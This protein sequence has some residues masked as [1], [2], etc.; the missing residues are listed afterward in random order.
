MKIVSLSPSITD[1]LV[2]IGA[3]EDIVGITPFCRPWL[4]GGSAEIAGDYFRIKEDVV[5]RLR[6][7]VIFLQSHVHDKLY[8]KL[9][10]EYNTHLISLP[11]SI[12]NAIENMIKIG[13]IV[14]RTYE[15]RALA[16]EVLS[17]IYGSVESPYKELSERPKVYVEYLWPDWSYSTAGAM[18][19][20][21][22]EVW[23][24]GGLNVFFESN[25]EFFTP[26]N[27]EILDKHPDTIFVNIEPWAMTSMEPYLSKRPAIKELV[28]QGSELILVNES[29]EVNLA[30]WG[31]TALAPTINM[32]RR[33]L[34]H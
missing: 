32:I 27:A 11:S 18:T 29:R 14:G 16:I 26:T 22:D 20:I 10:T 9:M 21:D 30:H 13:K 19:Y 2:S 12:L 33:H 23:L 34:F 28:D 3:E 7:D 15:A 1:V 4:K 5:S 17:E 6:P 31:P 25:K 8:R 24:A